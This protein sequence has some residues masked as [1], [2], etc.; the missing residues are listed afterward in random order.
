MGKKGYNVPKAGTIQVTLF[1]P[2]GTVVKMFVIM[3]NLNDMP[4][5]SQTFIRQ[6]TLYMP[7]DCVDKNLE[8]GPKWLRFLIHLRFV[9]IYFKNFTIKQFLLIYSSLIFFNVID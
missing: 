2:L 7:T 6:R 9:I 5:N 1:N 4:P 3:Y 8:W